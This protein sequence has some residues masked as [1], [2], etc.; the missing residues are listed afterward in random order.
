M[1]EIR[2]ATVLWNLLRPRCQPDADPRGP[3]IRKILQYSPAL[4]IKSVS[5]VLSHNLA[6]TRLNESDC[7]WGKSCKTHDDQ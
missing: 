3:Y 1:K 2:Y 5:W 6:S 7:A 4:L